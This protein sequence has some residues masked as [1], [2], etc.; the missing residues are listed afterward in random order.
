M[1]G[2]RTLRKALP[3]LRRRLRRRGSVMVTARLLLARHVYVC[4]ANEHLVFLD[5]RKD[6]YL[7]LGREQSLALRPLLT[8]HGAF[9]CSAARSMQSWPSVN[10][11][12]QS[13]AERG[14]VV[15]DSAP[16]R[17]LVYVSSEPPS[18]GM[19]GRRHAPPVIVKFEDIRKFFA[20]A[21]LTSM[22]LRWSSLEST[23]RCVEIRKRAA[24]PSTVARGT[25]A[26]ERTAA[27]HAL[28]QYYPRDYLCLFD[29][30]SLIEFLAQYRV[31][32]QWV[33]GVTME[34]FR[35]HCWVQEG[36]T[37]LNDTI[38]NVKNYT[39]IMCI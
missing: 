28:R 1:G 21:F 6:E 29:S 24:K 19:S 30:L 14:L 35:A 27:F 17:D 26:G 36:S 18:T 37:I 22:R 8:E 25:I 2:L 12:L 7:C 16:D 15:D 5:L 32:P 4:H 38:E 11:A 13:L 9:E 10:C 20:A 39:P 33:F 23:V 3:T 31:F 34:P